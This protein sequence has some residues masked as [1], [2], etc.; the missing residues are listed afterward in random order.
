M[1]Y[2]EEVWNGG[3]SNEEVRE[4]RARERR[5]D[6]EKMVKRKSRRSSGRW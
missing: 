3:A 5:R 6:E 2:S 4:L 1:I